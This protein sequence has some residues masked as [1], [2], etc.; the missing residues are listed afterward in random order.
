VSRNYFHPIVLSA[1]AAVAAPAL[2]IAQTERVSLAGG[3]AAIWNIAG[4]VNL[5]PGSGR[6]VEV[7]VTKRGPDAGRLEVAR[8]PIGG[9]ETLRIIYPG[10]DIVYRDRDRE[11]HGDRWRTEFRVR[12]DGTFGG[13]NHDRRRG[14]SGR[15]VRVTSSG[16]GTEAS[17]DLEITVPAG[18]ELSIFLAVGE[19]TARNVDGK[20]LLDTHGANVSATG[21]KGDLD[22]DTGSGDVR[23]DGMTGPLRV[24]VGSG[25]VTLSS[26][27]GASLDIDTG[28][29]EVRGTGVASGVLRIDTGS[30]DVELDGLTAQDVNVDVGS[31]N[32]E[33]GWTTDPGDLTVDS[34]SGDVVL[35]IPANSGATVDFESSSGDV[36]SDFPIQTTRVQR[37][38]LRGTFGDGKGRL[39]VESGSGSLKLVRR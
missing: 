4:M 31:G 16:S 38:A 34:G 8:G 14:E 29:G 6:A 25:D 12:E 7:T 17:A 23:V 18:T 28:S 15:R 5:T 26:V 3:R 36:D 13:D 33:L 20:I 2:L 35:T 19:I 24:D 22:I 30:G 10:D 39:A 1:L 11:M 9:R 32:V 21:M 37:D 27:S